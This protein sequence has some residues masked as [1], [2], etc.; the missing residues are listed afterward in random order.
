MVV[1]TILR[2]IEFNKQI[3]LHFIIPTNNETAINV[4]NIALFLFLI[5]YC[6]VFI[7]F[8]KILD[9]INKIISFL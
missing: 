9:K 8:L 5:E 4:I 7:T 6:F 2:W 3:V 1:L